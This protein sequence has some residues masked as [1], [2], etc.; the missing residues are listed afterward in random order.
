MSRLEETGHAILDDLIKAT[1]AID[2]LEAGYLSPR[3]AIGPIKFMTIVALAQALNRWGGPTDEVPPDSG[4][5]LPRQIVA[6]PT[7]A[8]VTTG[9]PCKTEDCDNTALPGTETCVEC[10]KEND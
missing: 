1:G 10:M 3:M 9:T 2:P 5:I 7:V 4:F 8:E 6:A